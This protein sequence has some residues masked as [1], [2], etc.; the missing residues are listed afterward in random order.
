MS[1]TSPLILLGLTTFA[2]LAF[3]IFF[4]IGATFKHSKQASEA[5]AFCK[6]VGHKFGPTICFI[7]FTN[8]LLT[9]GAIFLFISILLEA[10]GPNKILTGRRPIVPT[11]YHGIGSL[12]L[13]FSSLLP[14]LLMIDKDTDFH[15][16]P[17][18]FETPGIFWIVGGLIT[19]LGYAYLAFVL[20]SVGIFVVITYFIASLGFLMFIVAG[21][22]LLPNVTVEHAD[23]IFGLMIL[24][25][26][27]Y[28]VHGIMY[29]LA[30]Y[31]KIKDLTT[32][33]DNPAITFT[34]PNVFHN[35]KNKPDN[36]RGK[37][38]C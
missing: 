27:L 33:Q 24:G 37:E 31:K 7:E 25:S 12:F 1:S 23:M 34:N 22:M 4:T 32:N 6:N 10:F 2:K 29:P 17:P 35:K 9:T 13:L 5:F 16:E 15:Y 38:E 21:I 26:V 11:I 18:M 8:G 36:L 3:G 28:I 14:I 19:C 20:R 30:T